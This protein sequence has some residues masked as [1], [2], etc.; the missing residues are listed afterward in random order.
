MKNKLE[1]NK[2]IAEFMNLPL[3]PCNIGTENG[4]V[5]EGYLTPHVSVPVT[6]CGMQY[7][8]KWDWLMPLALKC[9]EI[10]EDIQADEWI[11]SIQTSVVSYKSTI[12]G[13]YKEIVEFIKWYNSVKENTF[14][15]SL[16]Q[17]N[18]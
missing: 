13:A 11:S 18:K 1:N 10:A 2:L 14:N 15:N 9:V 5:T 16:T 17:N 12:E 3:V 7:K 4:V 8:H 6:L